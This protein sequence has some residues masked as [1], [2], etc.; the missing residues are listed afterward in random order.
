MFLWLCVVATAGEQFWQLRAWPVNLFIDLD[1]LIALG[2]LL[3]THVIYAGLILALATVVLTV[4]FGRVFC[5]WICPLGTMSQFVGYL[6]KKGRT[7]ARQIDLNRYRGAQSLKYYILI[8]MLA[9]ALGNLPANLIR[10]TSGGATAITVTAAVLLV[11]VAYLALRKVI[12]S[13]RKA[14]VIFVVL[15]G[16]WVGL[17]FLLSE[18]HTAIVSLQTGLLDPISLVYRS[19]NLALLPAVDGAMEKISPL[20]KYYELAWLIGAI[21]IAVM[22]SNLLIPRFYCRFICPLG[23]ML[24][25]I[26]RPALLRVGKKS[27]QCPTCKACELHCEGACTP[28]GEIRSSECVMCLNCLDTCAAGTMSYQTKRSAAGEISLPDISR[29]GFL[30]SLISGLAVVPLMRLAG[31]LGRNYNA[32]LIRPPGA[33][34]EDEFLA[35]CIKCGQCIRV[36]PTNV[37]QPAGTEAGLEGLWT[38]RLNN[39]I[40][41]SGCQL[42]CVECSQICPTAAI[43]PITLDEKLGRGKFADPGPIRLGTAFVDRGRC[44]PHAMDRPCIVCQENCPVS[45]KAIFVREHFST[46]RDGQVT[47]KTAD[48][49]KLTVSALKFAPGQLA[50]GDYYLSIAPGQQA[51]RARIAD[52]TD[53]TIT[54]VKGEAWPSGKAD[55]DAYVKIRLQRP[56]VEP[57]RCIGCGVCEHECPL[58]GKAAIRVTAENETRSTNKALLA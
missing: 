33:L 31:R 18:D 2:T 14:A 52:N 36:C 57:A 3:T 28:S 7:N 15:V 6:G 20:G 38:P 44:L 23:A 51:R 34:V 56:Y 26:S 42:N 48:G 49:N 11:I 50:T 37:L 17:S 43:R 30:A 47:V 21:F 55:G 12:S 54:L 4:V 24:G 41:T 16:T 5:G 10:A 35:R 13:L 32:A 8:F 19:V 9:A 58:G 29:R 25:V 27:P 53:T 46:V 40:G 1:P 45:P 22:L 39:R